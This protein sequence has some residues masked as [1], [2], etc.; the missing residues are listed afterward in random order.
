MPD[1][2]VFDGGNDPGRFDVSFPTEFGDLHHCPATGPY[3]GDFRTA[4][5]AV[6]SLPEA[7]KSGVPLGPVSRAL[8]HGHSKM[9]GSLAHLREDRHL[10]AALKVIA[11]SMSTMVSGPPFRVDA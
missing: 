5:R 8:T 1:F 6:P 3:S 7:P 11:E 2:T 9:K 4:D 10:C